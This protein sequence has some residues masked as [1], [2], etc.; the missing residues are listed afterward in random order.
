MQHLFQI[1]L[2]CSIVVARHHVCL[3]QVGERR[4][5]ERLTAG[6]GLNLVGTDE[7]IHRFGCL[8]LN[9]LDI[10][11]IRSLEAYMRR[12]GD[13]ILYAEGDGASSCSH[14]VAAYHVGIISHVES[15]FHA[16]GVLGSGQCEGHQLSG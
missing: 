7:D 3:E 13:I 2:A 4:E 10:S 15:R 9:L 5:V 16:D 8:H 6:K 1:H 14:L 11:S 12:Q